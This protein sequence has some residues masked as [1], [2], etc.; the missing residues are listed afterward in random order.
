MSRKQCVYDDRD[1]CKSSPGC[2]WTGIPNTSV[3]ACSS[4]DYSFLIA[5][6]SSNGNAHPASVPSMPTTT[7]RRPPQ[8]H[9]PDTWT[10]E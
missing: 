4:K 9:R 5:P 1:L 3:G 10:H 8:Q 2:V 6:S 7:P